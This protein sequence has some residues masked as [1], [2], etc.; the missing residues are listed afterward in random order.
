MAKDIT[1]YAIAVVFSMAIFYTTDELVW[2]FVEMFFVVMVV[3]CFITER[4]GRK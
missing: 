4:K 1:L 3:K 2:F